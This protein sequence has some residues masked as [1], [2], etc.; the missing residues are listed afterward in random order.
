MASCKTQS[1]HRLGISLLELTVVVILLA[2]GSALAIPK[3]S[4]SLDRSKVDGA[5]QNVLRTLAMARQQCRSNFINATI[6]PNM[7][8]SQISVTPALDVGAGSSSVLLD[9]ANSIS[10][11]QF[12]QGSYSGQQSFVV[13]AFGD[14]RDT[15][16]GNILS[17]AIVSFSTP[18]YRADI[19]LVTG[20]RTLIATNTGG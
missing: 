2:I 18:R 3:F 15:A 8:S 20:T 7:N 10:N 1:N 13:D 17:S 19:D 16:S 9:L 6:T 5:A 11:A 14:V 4:G 12:L